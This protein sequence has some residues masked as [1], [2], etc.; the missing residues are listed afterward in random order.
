MPR[1]TT[2]LVLVSAAFVAAGG[3]IHLREWLDVSSRS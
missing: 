3:Y 2:S 1:F